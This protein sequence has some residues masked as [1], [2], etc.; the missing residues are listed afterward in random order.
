MTTDQVIASQWGYPNDR[1]TT[2]T[3]AHQRVQWV[4]DI[5][6]L[7]SPT[8]DQSYLYFDDGILTAIQD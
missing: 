1:H 6:P 8:L 4:Y 3:A 5:G 2:T 7:C